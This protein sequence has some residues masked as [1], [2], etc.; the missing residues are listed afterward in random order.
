MVGKIFKNKKSY[1]EKLKNLVLVENV[2]E[3]D[4]VGSLN[5]VALFLKEID[6]ICARQSLKALHGCLGSYGFGTAGYFN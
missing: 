3:I 1:Y 6:F 5:K 4:F 2:Q